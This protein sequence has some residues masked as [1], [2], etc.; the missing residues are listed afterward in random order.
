MNPAQLR[1]CHLSRNLSVPIC[2]S[3]WWLNRLIVTCLRYSQSAMVCH[4][5]LANITV[6][7]LDDNVKKWLNAQALAR[8]SWLLAAKLTNQYPQWFSVI[9]P[10]IYPWKYSE[11]LFPM[12]SLGPEHPDAEWSFGICAVYF[13]AGQQQGQCLRPNLLDRCRQRYRCCGGCQAYYEGNLDEEQIVIH[14]GS[15]G[16]SALKFT[17][18]KTY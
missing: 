8:T 14:N 3:E 17:P 16:D 13:T 18:L 15:G 12:R 7:K 6:D 4:P 11:K 10:Q 9:F 2:W 1:K 5:R